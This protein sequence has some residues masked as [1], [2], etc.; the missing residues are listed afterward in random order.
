M[1]A[2]VGGWG[3]GLSINEAVRGAGSLIWRGWSRIT[4]INGCWGLTKRPSS[5]K[6]ALAVPFVCS[7]GGVGGGGGGVGSNVCIAIHCAFAF[8][9]G[10][11]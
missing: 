6:R 2:C 7:V 5:F 3:A 10:L 4:N 9:L 11:P 8:C 1:C